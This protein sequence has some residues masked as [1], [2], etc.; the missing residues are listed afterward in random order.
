MIYDKIFVWIDYNL[1]GN[2][3]FDVNDDKEQI[4]IIRLSDSINPSII[5]RRKKNLITCY[6]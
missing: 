1:V 5:F 2:F 4:E 3:S 6:Y